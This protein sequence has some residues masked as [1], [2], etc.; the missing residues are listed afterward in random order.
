VSIVGP[1]LGGGH[2]LL[3]WFL[4]Q[5]HERQVNGFVNHLWNG[6]TTLEWARILVERIHRLEA[7]D[8]HVPLTQPGTEPVTKYALLCAF[9]DAFGTRHDVCPVEAETQ[10]SR[11]LVPTERRAPIA[12][13]LA[14]LSAWIA[15]N[16]GS[17]GLE[18]AMAVE[19]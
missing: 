14:T 7:G 5:P 3:G 11:T 16:V 17:R 12:E 13:Q 8:G 18:P 4:K 19:R 6:I 9:R 15:A 10:V 2:G 1:D